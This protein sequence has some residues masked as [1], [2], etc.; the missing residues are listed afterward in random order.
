VLNRKFREGEK[1]KIKTAIVGSGFAAN[2]HAEGYKR[3]LSSELV[4][5]ASPTEE[6][7]K[8]FASKHNLE[9][10]YTDY[11]EMLTREDINL[12]SVCVPNYRHHDVVVAAAEAG[13]HA[14]CEKPLAV[15]L[16]QADN[17]LNA[18]LQNGVRLFY[19]ENWLFA[20]TLVRISEIV[21]SGAVGDVLYFKA[22]EA[23][24]GSHSPYAL[25]K[26]YCG[27]GCL[28]HMAIHPIGYGL[29]LKEGVKPTRV[30]AEVSGGGENN[31][32]HPNCGGEDFSLLI[33]DFED[34]AR[35]LIEANYITKGGLDDTVEIYGT[36]GTIKV[37]FSQ[38]SPIK[39]F[40]LDGYDYAVEKAEMTKGWT[41]PAVDEKWSQG[42]IQEIEH[43]V[44]CIVTNEKPRYGADGEGGR[45]ALE[46]VMAG[47]ES[48]KMGKAVAL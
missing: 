17:M 42:C 22:K 3:C 38:G 36:E 7:V 40:S 28:I 48:A 47:Y 15:T 19:A 46:I 29:A 2:I 16:E 20:P 21:K 23:H 10:Y 30:Y 25:N 31:L 1:M 11:E 44:N 43:F 37:D 14:I 33:I 5:V 45:A 6:H 35:G 32:V 26:E 24:S 27:G 13:K 18:T 8:A 41:F 12:V 4:A 34:G 9:D 39:A